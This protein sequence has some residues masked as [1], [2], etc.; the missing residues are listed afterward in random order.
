LSGVQLQ[1]R[2]VYSF[3]TACRVSKSVLNSPPAIKYVLTDIF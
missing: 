2:V 1:S 3:V